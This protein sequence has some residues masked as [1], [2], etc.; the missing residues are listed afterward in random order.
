MFAKPGDLDHNKKL[1]QFGSIRSERTGHSLTMVSK[2][3][4]GLFGGISM[5]K[6]DLGIFEQSCDDG[7][8]YI[9]D[10]NERKWSQTNQELPPRAY[11]TA[12]F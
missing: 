11:H 12:A 7:M 4:A 5:Q 9:L 10:L 6:R 3:Q 1:C 8:I 2:N